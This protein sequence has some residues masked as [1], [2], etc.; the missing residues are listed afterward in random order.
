MGMK[1]R[2]LLWVLAMVAL[3]G[4]WGGTALA[5]QPTFPDCNWQCTSS[6]V[7]IA[8]VYLADADDEEL[9]AC[10]LGDTVTATV[11][12]SIA[13][14]AK[15]ARYGVSTFADVWVNGTAAGAIATC[16]VDTLTGKSTVDVALAEIEYPCGAG[17]ELRNALLI[18]R[19]NLGKDEAA[20]PWS[21]S[22]QDY[23]PAKCDHTATL[24]LQERELLVD[25]D[26]DAGCAPDEDTLFTPTVANAM[27]PLTYAWALGDDET[28]TDEAPAHAYA[29][30]GSYTVTLGVTEGEVVPAGVAIGASASK[31][32]TIVACEAEPTPSPTSVAP[33]PT[34]KASGKGPSSSSQPA[35][36]PTLTPEP[37]A[38]PEA[39]PAS[40]VAPAGAG[41]PTLPLVAA[42]L[43]GLA[44]WALGR[45]RRG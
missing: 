15:Q 26:V 42:T 25:F 34:K 35:P 43:A 4:L 14:G 40:G 13:N 5:Q 24:V 12:A 21:M 33:T 44:A 23:T 18:Y 41:W 3:M 20:C 37:L 38:L 7:S 11:W 36:A 28:S 45:K 9:P 16:A 17:V 31:T 27:A 10:T 1:L 30:A 39:L 32:I 29:A 19:N 8:A 6:D 22:C 2:T